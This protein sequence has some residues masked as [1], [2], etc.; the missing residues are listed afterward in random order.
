MSFKKGMSDVAHLQ[1]NPNAIHSFPSKGILNQGDVDK[2]AEVVFWKSD[3]FMALL[4][5]IGYGATVFIGTFH[6]GLVA[7]DATMIATFLATQVA[8]IQP[9]GLPFLAKVGRPWSMLAGACFMIM[10]ADMTSEEAFEAIDLN[11]LAL[12][13]GASLLS[14]N[15][16][17]CQ[18]Q[19]Q[20]IDNLMAASPEMLVLKM[21]IIACCMSWIITNDGSSLIISPVALKILHRRSELPKLPI[22]LAVSASANIG[23]A[24]LLNG[25]PQNILVDQFSGDDLSFSAYMTWACVPTVLSMVVNT[26]LLLFLLKKAYPFLCCCVKSPSTALPTPGEEPPVM[27]PSRDPS[28]SS[29]LPGNGHDS[30]GGLDPSDV[31]EDEMARYRMILQVAC[32]VM[33]ACFFVPTVRVSIGW[34]TSAVSIFVTAMYPVFT[35]KPASNLLALVDYELLLM[36]TG[37]FVVTGGMCAT[38]V[39]DRVWIA[40]EPDDPF[41]PSLL[42]DQLA[43]SAFILALS[44][45]V[46]NVPAVLLLQNSVSSSL[47]PKLSWQ[48]LAWMSTIAGNFTLLGSAANVIVAAAAQKAGVT[49]TYSGYLK[50]GAF[51]TLLCMT[52]GTFWTNIVIAFK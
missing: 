29:G 1:N 31:D 16:E 10:L 14:A 35:K 25:N 12:L 34:V 19:K 18:I 20:I 40:I 47:D 45:S 46:G 48:L 23:S 26:L 9:S 8:L 15:L 24:L 21:S 52:L 37:L 50:F 4:C 39:M 49:L 2:P 28:R 43:F 41:N 32:V 44:N 17:A 22:M 3:W 27:M 42:R 13:F 11:T 7:K 5:L 30:A 51:S 6:M 36:F 38:G 33:I